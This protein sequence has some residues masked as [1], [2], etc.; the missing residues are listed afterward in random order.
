[1]RVLFL[2]FNIKY[3]ASRFRGMSL[4][5]LRKFPS[6]CANSF[7]MS[8]CWLKFHLMPGFAASIEMNYVVLYQSLNIMKY[9]NFLILNYSYI[10]GENVTWSQ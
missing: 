9:I 7:I 10:T 8:G 6:F 3:Y 4:N 2:P 1:M 5:K